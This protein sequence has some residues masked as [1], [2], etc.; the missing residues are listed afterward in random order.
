MRLWM[1]AALLAPGMCGATGPA[2]SLSGGLGMAE[3]DLSQE[4]FDQL[5]LEFED[6]LVY[7][8]Q[9][10]AQF[11]SGLL[12][13]G[14][15][16]YTMYAELTALDTLTVAEDVAQREL[17]LG[18]FYA[19][20][21]N[22]RAGYRIGGGYATFGDITMGDAAGVFAEAGLTVRAGERWSWD[23]SLSRQELD[24]HSQN[25]AD[26]D[27]TDARL[28]ATFHAARLDFTFAA[29]Q[30]WLPAGDALVEYRFSV[31]RSWGATD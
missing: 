18:A 19:P 31:G 2:L 22:A 8:V 20:G 12:L 25:A 16:A 9:G 4:P 10:G 17:R 14:S 7:H 21:Q 5:E 15:Y 3:R 28:A 1:A 23:L 24:G 26:F 30:L 29:R 11:D 27:G 6:G 13:R